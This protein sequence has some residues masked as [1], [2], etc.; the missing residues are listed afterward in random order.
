MTAPAIEPRQ[1][2]LTVGDPNAKIPVVV[3]TDPSTGKEVVVY[4]A[5]PK[6]FACIRMTPLMRA[7]GE[8]GPIY[9][10]YGGAA[11][12]GKSHLA[13][14]LV[15]MVAMLWPG[16]TS[17]LFRRTL[18]ELRD[19][20]INKFLQEVPDFG[21]RLYTWNE[22]QKVIRWFNGSRTRMGYLEKEKDVFRYQGAE[23]DFMAFEEA[24]HYTLFQVKWLISNRL[25]ATVP[26]ATPFALFPSNPGNVGHAY[27]T[28]WFIQRRFRENERP[29]DY[30]FLQAKLADNFELRTRDPGYEIKLN[31]LE[32]PW[33]SW[34]RDGNFNA[35]PGV[36]LQLSEQEHIVPP[37]KVPRHWTI[38]GGL[39]WGYAHPFSFGIY[40]VAPGQYGHIY[41]IETISKAHLIDRQQIALIKEWG[42]AALAK[43]GRDEKLEQALQYIATG[44]DAFSK[45]TAGGGEQPS[46]AER[47]LEAQLPVVPAVDDRVPGLNN[48]RDYLAP[49]VDGIP[50]FQWMDTPANRSNFEQCEAMV[51]DPD[52]MEDVLK[53]NADEMGE[54]G[55]DGYDEDRY[56]LMSRPFTAEPQKTWRGG[57]TREQEVWEDALRDPN[58]EVSE[59]IEPSDN[60]YGDTVDES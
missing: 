13:R 44:P 14:T 15:T 18:D 56:A 59:T 35:G 37:F 32:E 30:A 24:T 19:N 23:Y 45:R 52:Y 1:A 34:L 2:V 57:K 60:I 25:R 4:A 10:G 48:F 17:I 7:K 8:P 41:K 53:V 46:T 11:G 33:R 38:F 40:T 20:H 50:G 12:G 54:G 5:Q 22:Q 6:Q 39:D 27:Y 31:A 51:T 36:A 47:Y 9:I 21:G 49:R 42:S 28:R 43:V 26:E 3:V 55:D 16:S 58:A 29:G